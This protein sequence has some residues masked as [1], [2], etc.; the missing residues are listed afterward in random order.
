MVFVDESALA[1]II[2]NAKTWGPVGKTPVRVYQGRWP[3]ASAIGGVT[4][5]GRLYLK[6][7]KGSLC[8]AQ[9]IA[10]LKHL[11]RHI[12]RRP[13][14]VFW[15]NGQP[16]RSKLVRAYLENNPRVEVHRLPGHSPELSPEKWVWAHLNKHELASF[17][18]HDLQE[19]KRRERLA[20]VRMRDRPKLL[21]KLAGSG[22]LP[23]GHNGRSMLG[24]LHRQRNS[25]QPVHGQCNRTTTDPD[26]AGA[27][28]RSLPHGPRYS[29]RPWAN[30]SKPY[31]PMDRK[32]PH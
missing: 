24:S 25:R 26:L 13:I 7:R 21:G 16:H 1:F 31:L 4:A 10:F 14:V 3:K 6:V 32:D 15:D 30:P 18:A 29:P 11:Q 5:R 2:Y 28:G 12:C 22:K 9:V 23:N 20:V 27:S 8:G 19:L 17:A